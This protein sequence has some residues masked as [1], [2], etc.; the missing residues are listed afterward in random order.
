MRAKIAAMLAICMVSAATAA[1]PGDLMD[2]KTNEL[3]NRGLLASMIGAAEVSEL[4]CGLKGQI[5]A[6]LRK[7]DRMAMHF[8]LNDKVDYSDVLFFA[9]SIMG[10]AKKTGWD[11]WCKTYRESVVKLFNEQ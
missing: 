6:A 5:D 8:D 7:A 9:T 2:E 3:T 11:K 4:R 1:E 10:C